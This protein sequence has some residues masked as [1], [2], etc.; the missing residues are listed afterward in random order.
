MN[1]I[2]R[3][4][5]EWLLTLPERFAEKHDK[6]QAV[7]IAA[8]EAGAKYAHKKIEAMRG[9]FSPLPDRSAGRS[10]D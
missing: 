1:D 9:Q 3:M 10:R 8:F 4:W 2:E 7:S 5:C 6:N